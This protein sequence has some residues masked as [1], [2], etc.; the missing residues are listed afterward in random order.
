MIKFIEHHEH[1]LRIY[2]TIKKEQ[3]ILRETKQ[4]ILDCLNNE[5]EEK[6]CVCQLLSPGKI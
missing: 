1:E 5:S 4:M 3:Q 6:Q 2:K